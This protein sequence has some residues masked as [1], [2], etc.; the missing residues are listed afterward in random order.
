[1]TSPIL[2]CTTP[3]P[4]V[5]D[6]CL[7]CFIATIYTKQILLGPN[8]NINVMVFLSLRIFVCCMLPIFCLSVFVIFSSKVSRKTLIGAQ[9]YTH[10]ANTF[11][12]YFSYKVHILT[13]SNVLVIQV[14]YFDFFE[15]PLYCEVLILAS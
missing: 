14:K 8:E 9:W 10:M 11:N 13:T 1:M 5:F 7:P 3:F 2:R 12:L 15:G 6:I 4:D